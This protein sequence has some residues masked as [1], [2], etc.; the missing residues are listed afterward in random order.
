MKYEFIF[1]C[2]LSWDFDIYVTSIAIDH[3]WTHKC[4][5]WELPYMKALI[6]MHNIDK[7]KYGDR[8]ES[9][10]AISQMVGEFEDGQVFWTPSCYVSCYFY[11]HLCAKEI[12]K[13]M[14][15]KL[16][17][18][19]P[20]LI[21]SGKTVG[22]NTTYCFTNDEWKT[23]LLYMYNNMEEMSQI[24]VYKFFGDKQLKD[25]KENEVFE[26]VV[27]DHARDDV[28]DDGGDNLCFNFHIFFF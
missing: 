2:L 1:L 28:E 16:E 22:P 9:E 18:Q 15:E 13:E 19:I 23:A 7:T 26:P 4:G 25:V 12:K 10:E 27:E 6:L 8:R 21:A 17:Q 20:I 24:F 11:R 5:L 3:N 14:M